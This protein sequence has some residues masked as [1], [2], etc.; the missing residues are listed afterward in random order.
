MSL[1]LRGKPIDLL[2]DDR[3]A[4]EVLLRHFKIERAAEE[5]ARH[6]GGVVVV[7]P[8]EDD[9]CASVGHHRAKDVLAGFPQMAEVLV[10][11]H[12]RQAEFAC[13]VENVGDVP[14]QVPLTLVD[15]DKNFS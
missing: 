5:V 9:L 2:A 4:V 15:D 13:L 6:E 8:A 7:E 14:G 3:R 1:R 12:Q 11:Q 10:R